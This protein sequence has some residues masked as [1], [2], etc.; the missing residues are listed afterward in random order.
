[1]VVFI[2]VVG[3]RRDKSEK[4]LVMDIILVTIGHYT[5]TTVRQGS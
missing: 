3:E 5:R 4:T 1:M 2:Y